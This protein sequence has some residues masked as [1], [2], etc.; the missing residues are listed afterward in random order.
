MMDQVH[1]IVLAAGRS[2]RMGHRDKLMLPIDGAPLLVRTVEAAA[3]AGPAEVI[4]VTGPYNYEDVLSRYTVR[5]VQNSDYEEGMGASIRSGVQA[6]DPA[7]P[8]YAILPGDMP[9]IRPRTIASAAEHLDDRSIVVPHFEGMPGHPVFFA[10]RFREE[11]LSLRGDVGARGILRAHAERVV[12]V[13]TEDP[14]IVRDI[15]TE[16]AY[17]R[18]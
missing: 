7:S 9:F 14:G 11:L 1:L 16:E 8:F 6:V 13:D 2:S 17:R 18:A 10:A 15:D 5:L 4:V 3:A 12:R